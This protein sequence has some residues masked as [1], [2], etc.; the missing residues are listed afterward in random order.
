MKRLRNRIFSTRRE[1][2]TSDSQNWKNALVSLYIVRNTDG[3]CLYYHHFQLG[4]ISRIET[5]LVGMGFSA[6]SKMMQEVVDSDS[7][8]SLIDLDKKKVIIEEKG[9]LLGILVTTKYSTVIREKLTLLLDH[10]EKIFQLQRAISSLGKHVCLEDYALTSDLVDLIFDKQPLKVL[11]I[12][13]IIFKSI[14]EGNISSL[15]KSKNISPSLKRKSENIVPIQN[16]K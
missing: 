16:K 1:D 10:F 4:S 5:Q 11:E 8:L 13:P 2:P 14:R 3:I 6:M 7:N 9:D 15:S 12:V